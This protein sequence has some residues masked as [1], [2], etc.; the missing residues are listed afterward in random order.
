MSN[1]P[2]VLAP[3]TM[4]LLAVSI[5]GCLA[6]FFAPGGNKHPYGSTDKPP[7]RFGVSVVV[8]ELTGCHYLRT[9]VGGLAPRL[10]ADGKPLC[11]AEV[12]R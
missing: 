2:P 7:A 5:V 3:I 12:P 10:G 6:A 4:V 9:P 1:R 8:D 11:G